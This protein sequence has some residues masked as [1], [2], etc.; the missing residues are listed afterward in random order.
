MLGICCDRICDDDFSQDKHLERIEYVSSLVK[1]GDVGAKVGVRMG[2]FAYHALLPTEPSQLYLIDPWEVFNDYMYEKVSR[3]FAPCE[4][5]EIL[6]MKPEDAVTLFPDEHFDY[7]YV[8]GEHSYEAVMSDLSNYLPKVK[9]GGYLIGDKLGSSGV[10][11]AV[12]QFLMMHPGELLRME[13]SLEKTGGQFAMKKLKHTEDANGK[14]LGD[15]SKEAMDRFLLKYPGPVFQ[16]IVIGD[17]IYPIGTDLCAPRYELIRP[18]LDQYDRPFSVLDLGAAQGY[19]SFRIANDYP[20]SACVMVEANQTSHYDRHGDML[21]DL[22]L[23]N[24][25]LNNIYYLHKKMDLSDLSFLNRNEHFDFII[26]FL[27]VNLMD[28]A[29]EKQMKLID[30]LFNLGE[31]L[32]LEVANDVGVIHTSY[33]EYLSQKLDCEYLGEVNRHKNPNSNSKGKLFWFKKKSTYTPITINPPIQNETFDNLSGVYP[34]NK[35]IK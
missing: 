20:K 6:R 30:C 29:L 31:N 7:V 2:N 16:D 13:E 3:M 11:P 17:A 1:P 5:V 8:D 24:R 21:N 22:C 12:Q 19:F 18:I 32:I 23:L 27:V 15:A 26:A 33:V 35:E 10:G 9:V 14:L 25:H 28:D 34:S 4:N